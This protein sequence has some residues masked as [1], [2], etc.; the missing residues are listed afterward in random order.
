VR[1][2]DCCRPSG[3][4]GAP[5]VGRQSAKKAGSASGSRFHTY[6]WPLS[7]HGAMAER[8]ITSRRS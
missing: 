6:A 5:A 1:P 7:A 2:R 4:Q 8:V 3:M